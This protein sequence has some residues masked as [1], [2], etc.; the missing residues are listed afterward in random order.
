M[1]TWNIDPTQYTQEQL[2]ELYYVV[3]KMDFSIAKEIYDYTTSLNIISNCDICVVCGCKYD[4]TNNN[5]D[6]CYNCREPHA[7]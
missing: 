4:N 7:K 2:E 6:T 5:S 3:E 1:I